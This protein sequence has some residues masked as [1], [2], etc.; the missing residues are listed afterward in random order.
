MENVVLYKLL[1][2]CS[3]LEADRKN[4][5]ESR[6]IALYSGG[7]P[8]IIA[9]Y[10]YLVSQNNSYV[11]LFSGIVYILVLLLFILF[12][13]VFYLNISRNIYAY[14]NFEVVDKN[15]K[16]VKEILKKQDTVKVD[17]EGI[18]HKIINTSL[19]KTIEENRKTTSKRYERFNKLLKI[20]FLIMI[21]LTIES[22]NHAKKVA[23]DKEKRVVVIK[24]EENMENNKDK[25]EEMRKEELLKELEELKID[26]TVSYIAESYDILNEF[27]K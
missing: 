27:K 24:G 3:N 22:L 19:K 1:E 20:L 21:L 6:T 18:N 10:S 9:W 25:K 13:G 26:D 16:E 23:I 5:V 14:P 7:A 2:H 8:T 12:S 17:L 11:P 15:F 4:I